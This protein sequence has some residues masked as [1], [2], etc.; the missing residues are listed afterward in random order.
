MQSWRDMKK[1]RRQLW[2]VLITLMAGEVAVPILLPVWKDSDSAEVEK[3]VVLFNSWYGTK[4]NLGGLSIL[5]RLSQVVL[6]KILG[7]SLEGQR[8]KGFRMWRYWIPSYPGQEPI[9]FQVLREVQQI[10]YT[11]SQK[12]PKTGSLGLCQHFKLSASEFCKFSNAILP[13]SSQLGS[14]QWFLSSMRIT[15]ICHTPCYS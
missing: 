9:A 1:W 2:C 12:C 15:N 5:P 3:W 8:G 11:F 7:S 13:Q 4:L 10:S 14:W 6:I